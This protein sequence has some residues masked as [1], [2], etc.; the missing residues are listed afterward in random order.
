[1]A[2]HQMLP[3]SDVE[4]QA[5]K[6]IPL[7]RTWISESIRSRVANFLQTAA[8]IADAHAQAIRVNAQT[9]ADPEE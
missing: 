4:R 6:F 3:R 1:M 5:E 7:V 8:V 2:T 9:F